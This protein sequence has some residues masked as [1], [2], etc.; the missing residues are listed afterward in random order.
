MTKS[1]L[2]I[3]MFCLSSVLSWAQED[4]SKKGQIE[5]V[6]VDA[7]DRSVAGAKVSI[8]SEECTVVGIEPTAITDEHGHFLLAGVPVGVSG[9]FAQKLGSG[10]PDTTSAIYHDDSALPPKVTVR[11]GE[12]ASG[13]VVRLGRKAGLILGEVVDE[14]NLQPVLT[15][16]IKISLPDNERIMLSIGTD[17]SG[18][19]RL[20]IPAQPVRLAVTASGYETWQFTE[21]GPP[22]IIHIE[23][24]ARRE[25]TIKLHKQK[26]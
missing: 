7:E 8:L 17:R 9:V 2:V 1:G 14:E 3:M 6:V 18:R 12:T 22:G 24:E 5:G 16:R 23:P 10:Y 25:L 13:V 20:L 11:S 26:N 21:Q 4:C 15:A 19:F